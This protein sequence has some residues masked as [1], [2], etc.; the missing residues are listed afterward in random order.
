MLAAFAE[1]LV[2]GHAVDFFQRRDREERSFPKQAIS[3]M[4]VRQSSAPVPYPQ[5][6]IG[7]E[8]LVGARRV[9]ECQSAIRVSSRRFLLDFIQMELVKQPMDQRSQDDG[10]HREESDPTVEGVKGREQLAT[11]RRLGLCQ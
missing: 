10:H 4:C 1:A 5:F 2:V 3:M 7:R 11:F 9:H 6:L 8:Q